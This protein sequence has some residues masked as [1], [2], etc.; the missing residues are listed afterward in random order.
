MEIVFKN[1][2]G[3]DFKEATKIQWRYSVK[4]S[5][6]GLTIYLCMGAAF[7]L[8]GMLLGKSS[9]SWNFTTNM[10]IAYLIVAILIVVGL[11]TGRAKLMHNCEKLISHKSYPFTDYKLTEE[12]I[13][14]TAPDSYFESSWTVINSYQIYGNFLFLYFSPLETTSLIINRN[15]LSETDFETLLH[16]V[17]EGIPQKD[18]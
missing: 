14:I 6:K 5:I 1:P 11:Y 2:I 8:F 12:K 18:I 15:Q 16:F 17:K 9:D 4:K 7:L 3:S 13:Y 10:G